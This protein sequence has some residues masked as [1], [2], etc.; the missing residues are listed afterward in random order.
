MAELNDSVSPIL[1][2]RIKVIQRMIGLDK[3]CK[4][5]IQPHYREGCDSF[6]RSWFPHAQFINAREPA[7]PYIAGARVILTHRDSTVV[8]DGIA[9][10]K[11]VVLLPGCNSSYEPGRFKPFAQ[12]SESYEAV[13]NSVSPGPI[14]QC[15]FNYEHAKA[16]VV[17]G[18]A[19][20]RIE[21][22]IEGKNNV[23]S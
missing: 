7:M 19:S 4:L 2:N 8:L 21:R 11:Q 15:D 12:E 16:H 1:H 22:I 17:L 14:E 13:K 3:Y 10:H 18:G 23:S 5:M 9:A 6:L 20:A